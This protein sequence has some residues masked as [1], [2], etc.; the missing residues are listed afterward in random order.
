MLLPFP[1]ENKTL[2]NILVYH[3]DKTRGEN[4]MPE[5]VKYALV[6]Q[7]CLKSEYY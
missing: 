1:T 4:L 5:L 2:L 3:Y 7:G 6:L